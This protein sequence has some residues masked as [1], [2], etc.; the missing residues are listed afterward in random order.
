VVQLLH[1]YEAE[2][3]R[4]ILH[5]EYSIIESELQVK[6]VDTVTATLAGPVDPEYYSWMRNNYINMKTVKTCYLRKDEKGKASYLTDLRCSERQNIIVWFSGES[7]YVEYARRANSHSAAQVGGIIRR[8]VQRRHVKP[9]CDAAGASDREGSPREIGA[10]ATGG[11]SGG[12]GGSGK[13]AEGADNAG[14]R[15]GRPRRR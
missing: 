14:R 2:A 4:P 10:R 7:D 15:E 11:A 12:A 13:A 6:F 5:P 3:A 8:V 1:T 9:T